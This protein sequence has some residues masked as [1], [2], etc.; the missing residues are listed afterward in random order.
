MELPLLPRSASERCSA[1]LTP[2][3]LPASS[4]SPAPPFLTGWSLCMSEGG[5][6]VRRPSCLC[7]G[8]SCSAL[9]CPCPKYAL[10]ERLLDTRCGGKG[11]EYR[12]LRERE[13]RTVGAN[14]LCAGG[15]GGA[16][17]SPERQL[18]I[19]E[20]VDSGRLKRRGQHSRPGRRGR[21]AQLERE[22]LPVVT[23]VSGVA[24]AS[25]PCARLRTLGLDMQAQALG[26][27]LAHLAPS[28]SALQAPSLAPCSVILSLRT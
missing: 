3:L 9:R 15:S 19:R 12:E 2:S 6:H 25:C 18:L 10:T 5:N 1:G 11:Q 24:Q 27:S 4:P 7:A 8:G 26:M 21:P 16:L 22:M 28:Y 23:V 14:V 20:G 17:G 13:L